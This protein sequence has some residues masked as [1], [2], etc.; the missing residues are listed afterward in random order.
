MTG[1][2]GAA[3]TFE[4]RE[5][6]AERGLHLNVR[7]EGEGAVDQ[8]DQAHRRRDLQFAAACLV[9]LTATQLRALRKCNSASDMVLM[10]G[11]QVWRLGPTEL[12]IVS[13][14]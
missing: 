13:A 2:S 5:R 10:I 11:G 6:H 8:I 1:P 9:G 3:Q 14:S 12:A 4:G 7:V